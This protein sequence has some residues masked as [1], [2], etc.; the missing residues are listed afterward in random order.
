MTDKEK[1]LA[2]KYLRLKEK[3]KKIGEEADSVLEMLKMEA[4]HKVGE[5]IRWITPKYTKNTGSRWHPNLV[6]IPEKVNEAVLCDIR[7][8]ITTY[9]NIRI[10]YNY[11]F[12]PLKKDGGISQNATYP[13][14]TY[15]WT[16]KKYE[17]SN[18]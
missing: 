4:P 13:R 5:I 7:V 16:G 18:T 11:D 2:E 17:Q 1:T 14:N 3:Q 10:D 8:I 9:N 6:E 15:E 12:R